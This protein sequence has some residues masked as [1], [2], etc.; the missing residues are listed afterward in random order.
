MLTH[1][2]LLLDYSIGLVMFLDRFHLNYA[3][4]KRSYG[5]ITETTAS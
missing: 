5:G 4:I 1:V 2:Q 3:Q